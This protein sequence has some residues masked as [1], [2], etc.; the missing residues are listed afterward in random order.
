MSA[1][2]LGTKLDVIKSQV[3]SETFAPEEYDEAK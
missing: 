2:R 3:R 1:G